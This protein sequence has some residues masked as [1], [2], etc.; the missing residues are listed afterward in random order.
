MKSTKI[1]LVSALLF[2]G[3]AALSCAQSSPG[4]A[5][6]DG[7][8]ALADVK[9]QMDMGPR[10]MDSPAHAKIVDWILAELKRA[11]WSADIPEASNGA[12]K[13]RNI[14]GRRGQGRPWIILGA[15]YDSRFLSDQDPDRS[16]RVRPVPGANDGASGVAVLLELARVLPKDLNKRIELL[17]IDAEDNG[18]IPGWDWCLGS[19]AY[20]AALKE[21][22]DS[23]IIIDMIGDADL[24]IY[25]EGFS[26]QKLTSEIWKVAARLGFRQFINEPKYQM[27]DDHLPFIEK[28]MTAIDIIDFDYPYW[29]TTGDTLDKVSAESLRAVGETLLAWLTGK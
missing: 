25:R 10:I 4:P 23:V 26:D 3:A 7:K 28:G 18:E 1:A 12:I 15:H 20:A 21:K 16:K 2:A 19:K 17:F 24:N 6:F 5:H 8:R 27:D 14:V 29:H 11:G 13:I 9:A 22:P